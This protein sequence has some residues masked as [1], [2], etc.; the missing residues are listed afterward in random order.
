[1]EELKEY[2]IEDDSI[3]IKKHYLAA[4]GK[5][6]S[7]DYF[8]FTLAEEEKNIKQLQAEN[9][10]GIKRFTLAENILKNED[11]EQQLA[12]SSNEELI[13][14][15]LD[16]YLLLYPFINQD[17]VLD[18]GFHAKILLPLAHLLTDIKIVIEKKIQKRLPR[19]DLSDPVWSAICSQIEAKLNY[20]KKVTHYYEWSYSSSRS[21]D[22][23]LTSLPP[24]GRFIGLLR[25][26]YRDKPQTKETTSSAAPT[27]SSNPKEALALE[28]VEA[29][30]QQ[31]KQ[32]ES[33]KSH[34]FAPQNSFIRRLQH[35][36]IVDAGFVSNSVGEGNDRA[37]CIAREK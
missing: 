5:P 13:A 35:K 22:L 21:K 34:T 18:Y 29:M 12:Q 20:G 9:S 4:K 10:L 16:H 11:Y 14:Q 7:T 33:L 17:H 26:S 19:Y 3:N 31:F 23:D 32:D 24:V 27:P 6:V 8:L 25:K 2:S 1:M 30:L 15:I 37:V 28:E 36:K